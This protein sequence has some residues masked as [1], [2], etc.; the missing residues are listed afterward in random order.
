M[1][2]P[3]D[4]RKLRSYD[5]TRHDRLTGAVTRVLV[6]EYAL[7]DFGPFRAEI[8]EAL[9]GPVELRRQVTAKAA[10]LDLYLRN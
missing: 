4:Y 2:D 10:T 6:V 9:D 5:D 7:G 8:P 1:A 3:V